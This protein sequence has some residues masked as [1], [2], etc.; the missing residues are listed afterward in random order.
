MNM[1]ILKLSAPDVISH[2]FG[3]LK[4]AN[5]GNKSLP[6]SAPILTNLVHEVD[7]I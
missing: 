7:R 1:E 6:L 3:T 2:P 5:V 4:P